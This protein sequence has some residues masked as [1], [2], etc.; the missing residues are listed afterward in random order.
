MKISLIRG[1]IPQPRRQ[2]LTQRIAN[3]VRS[4][5]NYPRSI[6]HDNK[7]RAFTDDASRPLS[8]VSDDSR[9]HVES[10]LGRA[11]RRRARECPV[12]GAASSSPASESHSN[13]DR[14]RDRA[15]RFNSRDSAGRSSSYAAPSGRGCRAA[16]SPLVAVVVVVDDVV[17]PSWTSRRRG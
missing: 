1:K 7:V 6:I 2:I 5:R 9:A 8:R 13:R 4:S 10:S 14:D 12:S 16:S 3:V 17:E 11:S 15:S